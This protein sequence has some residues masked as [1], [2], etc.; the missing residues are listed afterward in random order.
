MRGEQACRW[1]RLAYANIWRWQMAMLCFM[2]VDTSSAGVMKIIGRWHGDDAV[3]AEYHPCRY[4]AYHVRLLDDTTSAIAYER[5]IAR[6][7]GI[8]NR[9]YDAASM[10]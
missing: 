3:F 7:I 1:A 8:G 4:G 5:A 6:N 10:R 2:S 9:D